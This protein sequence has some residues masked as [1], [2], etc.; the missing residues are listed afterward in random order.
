MKTLDQESAFRQLPPWAQWFHEFT[1]DAS[2]AFVIVLDSAQRLIGA[3]ARWHQFFAGWWHWREG[4]Q[5]TE[6]TPAPEGSRAWADLAGLI[7]RALMLGEGLQAQVSWQ[8]PAAQRLRLELALH[9]LRD[10]L[11]RTLGLSIRGRLAP[12]VGWP[13][14]PSRSGESRAAGQTGA[15][16]DLTGSALGREI[17]D[18]LLSRTGSFVLTVDEHGTI[19]RVHCAPRDML[20]GL[21]PGQSAWE[22]IASRHHQLVRSVCTQVHIMGC[23][24]TL[25]CQASAPDARWYRLRI[26]IL[27]DPD[28]GRGFLILSADITAAKAALTSRRRLEAGIESIA[29]GV[30]A[31]SPDGIITA[32]NPGAAALLGFNADEALGRSLLDFVPAALQGREMESLQAALTGAEPAAGRSER[33]RKDGTAVPVDVRTRPYC[34][35]AGRVTGAVQI[36]HDVS[37]MG[38]LEDQLRRGQRL[39]AQGKLAAMSAHEIGNCLGI[40]LGRAELLRDLRKDDPEVQA[41]LTPLLHAAGLAGRIC[42][43][44]RTL[45]WSGKTFPQEVDLVEKLRQAFEVLECVVP[46]QLQ[47]ESGD[48]ETMMVWVDPAQLDLV[49]INLVLNARDATKPDGT[50]SLK[51]GCMPG[52]RGRQRRYF[53]EVADNGVGIPRAVL[54]KLFKTY[55]TTKPYGFGTGLGL[56]SVA[57]YVR[58]MGGEV[59]IDSEPGRGTRVRVQLPSRRCTVAKTARTRTGE[60]PLGRS[61]S[62]PR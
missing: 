45:T 39:A 5:L 38:V 55:F 26:S 37:E 58:Q 47:F 57:R 46:R 34:G 41:M 1:R 4:S 53:F 11:G 51:V 3:N 56:V 28:E 30:V 13:V 2:D 17:L 23:P 24:I 20:A 44:F 8:G 49:L 7:H 25:E 62:R 9:P 29:D 42:H 27:D 43:Q 54:Q 60:A 16:A 31:V 32:W 22:L 14:W 33:L 18:E 10:G 48:A 50:I 6:V 15:D 52:G 19:R 36:V 21:Q 35:A 59:L 61:C 40:V 12:Q